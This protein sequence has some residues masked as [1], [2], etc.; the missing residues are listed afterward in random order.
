MKRWLKILISVLLVVVVIVAGFS[1]W[2][3]NNITAVYT[4]VMHDQDTLSTKLEEKR[5]EQE[6]TLSS[7]N[8]TVKAL[9]AAQTGDLL[10]GKVSAEEVKESLGI[11]PEL[12][13]EAKAETEEKNVNSEKKPAA[14]PSS[15]E[16]KKTAKKPAAPV[17]VPE[18][19]PQQKA[20]DLMNK[21]A[22]EL[23]A[24]EVDLMAKL[25]EMK[26]S[27]LAKWFSIP[28]E[29]KSD[30]KL[31]SIGLTGLE[32]CYDLEVL[33][34]KKV[35]GILKRYRGQLEALGTDTSVIDEIW[36]YYCDK[37]ANQKAYYLNKYIN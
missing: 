15:S 32:E 10:D 20:E 23:Y 21:C 27:A 33:A 30:D 8:V 7:F 6:A 17:K 26:R 1:I 34:D 35:R 13:E 2:Q 14:K 16:K 31:I 18:K 22:A 9:D 28:D 19:T 4:A 11:T 12:I 25:G 29:D 24:C 3:W 37:K 36:K 5:Q